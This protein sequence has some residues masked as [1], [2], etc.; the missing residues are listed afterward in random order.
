MKLY[1]LRMGASGGE[2]RVCGD[3]I[4]IGGLR[5]GACG[6]GGANAL[7]GVILTLICL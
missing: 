7:F 2:M 6:G 5:A 1:G 4:L 3:E